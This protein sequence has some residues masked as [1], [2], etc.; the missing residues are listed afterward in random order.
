MEKE[1]I[2]KNLVTIRGKIFEICAATG[3]RMD[4]ITLIA[5]TKTVPCEGIR[6]ALADGIHEIGESRVQE[7][8]SKI[9]ELRG[10]VRMHMIGHLQSNKVKKAVQM[11]DVIQS[12]DSIE[13]ANEISRRA[14]EAGRS[15]E[16]LIEVNSSGES[17]KQGVEPRHALDLVKRVRE[18]PHLH[19]VGLMTIGPLSTKENKIRESFRHTREQFEKAK[20]IVGKSF[21]TLSMGMSGDYEIAIEE[22][23]TMLRLGGAIFGK[24]S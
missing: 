4:E 18:L 23:S 2:A 9:E 13:L 5:V 15:I 14:G 17:Q 6:M 22:G 20:D 16:C 21:H 12:I 11:F 19:L 7:A 1:T 24:R 10:K 3:R 8:E